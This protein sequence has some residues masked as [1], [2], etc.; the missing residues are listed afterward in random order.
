MTPFRENLCDFKYSNDTLEAGVSAVY[1]SFET[2]RS[3]NANVG[4]LAYVVKTPPLIQK[5]KNTIYK[6]IDS[7]PFSV[8]Q[9]NIGVLNLENAGA[10]HN[11]HIGWFHSY[12]W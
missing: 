10:R 5:M 2:Y 7:D 6:T 3:Q 8:Y 11:W 12:R 9:Q 1:R 4:Y